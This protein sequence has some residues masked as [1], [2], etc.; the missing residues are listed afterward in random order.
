M[1]VVRRITLEE[2]LHRMRKFREKYGMSFEEFEER[3]L[4]RGLDRKAAAD[5]YEWAGLVHSYRRY[6]E[7]GELDYVLEEILEMK[8]EELRVL[9]PRRI[10]LLAALATTRVE[11]ISDLARKV[12]RNVKNVYQDLQALRR[13]GWVAFRRRG[14]RNLV[15]EPLVD[16]I[17]LLIR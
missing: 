7:E 8:P 11:S 14:R 13:L 15:P 17:T 3:F 6:V 12:R 9:T 1:R 2:A 16:E 10:E 4:E 5:Y